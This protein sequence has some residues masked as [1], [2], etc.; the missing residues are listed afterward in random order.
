MWLDN[1]HHELHVLLT[2][3]R[4][5][6]YEP[7]GSLDGV[8]RELTRPEPERLIVCRAEPRPGR[9]PR[10]RRPAA[11]GRAPRR[12]RRRA[13]LAQHA[14]PLHGRGA[15]RARAVPVLHRP[16]RPARSPTRRARDASASSP[17]SR[18][19]PARRCRTRRTRRPLARSRI[20]HRRADPFYRELLAAAAHAAARARR[21]GRRQRADDAPRRRRRSSPTSTRRRWSS[22]RESRGLAGP[23]VPARPG[24]GRRGDEL[25]A[26]LG[27][28][29]ARR[30][31][32]LRR[33]TATRSAIEVARAHRVQLALLPAGRRPGPALRLPRARPVR[34]GDRQALQPGEAADRPVREGDRRR[35]STGT[36]RTRCRTSRRRRRRRPRD[37]RRPTRRRRCRS[38][39]SST[40]RSTGR[41]T[42]PCARARRW[43][44]TVIYEVHVKG[45]TKL[46][47]RRARG[48][49]RHVRRPRER[50]C[51]RVPDSRSA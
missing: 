12:A 28:R 48:P 38:P 46:R 7:F 5:G 26:L 23:A 51:D 3:E 36:P 40:R 8:V 17:R 41:T 27:E 29:R 49:A 20:S 24:V 45:F 30:A 32:P 37:R 4:E 15:R 9:Q 10:A 1:L 47:E 14:A 42:T 31:L 11:A 25:L 22:A 39:S 2:G 33:A 35:A 50:G 13:L 21:R 44:E 34:P 16:H 18:R 6:Y 19:S 43:N